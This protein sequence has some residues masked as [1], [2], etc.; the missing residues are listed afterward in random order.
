MPEL[1]EV[2][3]Y[4]K[5][6]DENCL[7]KKILEVKVPVPSLLTGTTANGLKKKLEGKKL[8]AT[9]R[10]G[11]YLFAKASNGLWLYFHF[12]LTGE[13][14]FESSE[15]PRF[16]S[17]ML[18]YKAGTLCFADMRKFGRYGIV[19]DPFEF[20]SEKGWGPDALSITAPEFIRRIRHK[21][22][23]VKSAL[24]DQKIMAGV[25]NEYSDEIL[26]RTRIHPEKI[27]A[28]LGEDKLR[29]IHKTM[30]QVLNGVVKVNAVRSKMKRYP[31]VT[32]RKKGAVCPR[33]GRELVIKTI[34]G[35]TSYFCGYCQR[36]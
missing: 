10:H 29:D 28:E 2:E 1:P 21:R 36:S 26:F 24:M 31:L 35:R 30:K 23:P 15:I 22:V 14:T 25:G 7:N 27:P 19:S 33:C 18:R 13:L 5:V 11:K 20:L 17:L 3:S 34:G 16:T 12:G 4:R 32:D 6:I 8:T 9:Y